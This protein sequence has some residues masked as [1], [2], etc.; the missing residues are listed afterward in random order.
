MKD[1]C[2]LRKE[3]EKEAYEYF[4]KNIR[5]LPKDTN[6]DWDLSI[7]KFLYTDIDAFRHAYVS[8]VFTQEYNAIAISFFRVLNEIF[9]IGS[10]SA[11]IMDF[12]N[13]LVGMKYGKKTK[14]REKLAVILKNALENGELIIRPNDEKQHNSK[15][16]FNINANKPV[17]MLQKNKTCKNEI[18]FDLTK[19][20]MMSQEEFIRRSLAQNENF[21]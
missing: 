2:S 15:A 6:G 8:G 1:P 20:T 21:F 16:N 5:K 10:I 18:F 14:S 3:A 12:L 13:N 9:T 19:K 11:D 17:I 4:N 7:D